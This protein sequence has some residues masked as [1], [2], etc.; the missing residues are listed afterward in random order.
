MALID[1]PINISQLP[2]APLPLTGAELIPADR[3]MGGQTVNFTTGQLAAYV[4]QSGTSGIITQ[5][6]AGA[7]LIGGGAGP[8]VTLGLGDSGVTP[9]TYTLATITVD[10]FGRVVSA[11]NGH[12]ASAIASISSSTL[13][14]EPSNP[15]VTSG[16]ID[17]LQTG[18]TAGSYTLMSA[19]VD[20]YGR[21]TAASNG[22]AVTSVGT[23]TGLTGGPITGSGTISI[24]NTAVTPGTYTLATVTVNAQGQITSASNGSAPGTGT[25]TSITAG[26]GLSGGTITT[27]GTIALANTAVTAGSY[28]TADITVDAQGRITAAANGTVAGTGTVTS[29]TQGTGMN[30]SVNPITTTGTINLANTAVSAGSYTL[31]SLTVDAQGRLTSA[32]NGTAVTSITAGTGLSGGTITTT[33][34]INIANTGVTAAS[35]TIP[36]ITVNAQ[37]QITAASSGSAVTSVATGTGLTGGPITSTG[38]ILL[39]DTA[40]TPG[41][42]TSTNIT[43]DQQGRITAAASGST[44]SISISGGTG[45]T[46]SPNPIVGTGTV[47]IANTAVTPGTYYGMFGTVNAQGQLTAA[48]SSGRADV[49]AK[50]GWVGDGTTDNTTA[51]QT[52]LNSG[53]ALYVPPGNYRML[54][55][56][57]VG[58]TNNIDVD[59]AANA[60]FYCNKS[61]NI[62]FNSTWGPVETCTA[63]TEGTSC[64]NGSAFAPGAAGSGYVVGDILELPQERVILK[65]YKLA[66]RWQV[67]TLSGSGVATMT[68]IQ[69]GVILGQFTASTVN[70]LALHSVTGSGSGCTL[71]ANATFSTAPSDG[72]NLVTQLS[73]VNVSGSLSADNA[74]ITLDDGSTLSI[75]DVIKVFSADQK[76][77]IYFSTS[78]Q[79][80]VATATIDGVRPRIVTGGVG[81]VVNDTI[82]IARAT[83]SPVAYGAQ[84]MPIQV[85][86]GTTDCVLTVDAV[87][88]AGAVTQC[89]VSNAGLYKFV[90]YDVVGQGSTTGAGTGFTCMLTYNAG[91]QNVGFGEMSKIIRCVDKN[92]IWLQRVLRLPHIYDAANPP[93]IRKLPNTTFYWKGGRFIGDP[94]VGNIHSTAVTARTPAGFSLQGSSRVRITDVVTAGVFEQFVQDFC[95]YGGE[96]KI[97]YEDGVFMRTQSGFGYGVACAGSTMST[98]SVQAGGGSF[99]IETGGGLNSYSSVATT[100]WLIGPTFDCTFQDSVARGAGFGTHF[101]TMF[102]TWNNCTAI[103]GTP[104]YIGTLAGDTLARGM[105]NSGYMTTFNGFRTVDCNIGIEERSHAVGYSGLMGAPSVTVINNLVIDRTNL[106]GNVATPVGVQIDNISFNSAAWG[107]MDTKCKTIING[108]TMTKGA[109]AVKINE[110]AGTVTI[111]NARIIDC[112]TF[113][114]FQTMGN[115]NLLDN[116]F[117]CSSPFRVVTGNSTIARNASSNI[118]GAVNLTID[119][120][121]CLYQGASQATAVID[122][123]DTSTQNSLSVWL[124]DI[125]IPFGNDQTLLRNLGG[126]VSINDM[127]VDAFRGKQRVLAAAIGVNLNAGSVDTTMLFPS[128]LTKVLVTGCYLTNCTTNMTTAR[129][130]LWSSA[131]G[132][133]DNFAA[134]QAISGLTGTSSQLYQLT[135]STL[136]ATKAE[137]AQ[138]IYFRVGTAQGGAATADVYI[139]GI[140]LSVS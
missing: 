100:P 80:V 48:G 82:T 7:G 8:T 36:S 9:A 91:S 49:V 61:T 50:Y 65:H 85:G 112:L 70:T 6:S 33:G 67:T 78:I 52:A 101:A 37:G 105:T 110:G 5:V 15:L 108:M 130:S 88:S 92:T 127:R 68:C 26:T 43:V 44:P 28:T 25:V 20:V 72:Q 87:T 74:T 30:F 77:A 58:T 34:T 31:A 14:L 123:Q 41:S 40:V 86:G 83:A 35:Y 38:T 120:Q 11:S 16:S 124:G 95:S 1:V 138:Q 47:S 119:G 42:Y 60:V 137:T 12:G 114:N 23:G 39:A 134:D 131:G 17:L 96:F 107:Q 111:Q 81:Y 118:T 45:I 27:S 125:H 29:I 140:D 46:T 10:E 21:L 19:T 54:S 71:G 136:S 139:I 116:H 135:M 56:V 90:N 4:V 115:L 62:L 109:A 2:P 3:T 69:P 75:G 122:Q 126:G 106:G 133:G 13:D 103:A 57:T 99:A 79:A 64:T 51:I 98:Y 84:V 132:L 113:V 55:A 53:D 24:A 63:I 93:L 66:P 97:R 22:T 76:A 117:D 59:C 89:H 121:R 18:V 128:N 104:D 129:C 94:N 32:S 102:C 73:I